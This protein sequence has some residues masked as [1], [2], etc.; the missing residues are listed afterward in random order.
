[1]AINKT[2][3]EQRQLQ[4][5]PASSWHWQW[6]WHRQLAA[7]SLAALAAAGGWRLAATSLA[8]HP[9][10]Q[11]AAWQ[12]AAAAGSWQLANHPHLQYPA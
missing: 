9:H 6:Q 1:M 4:L 12:L 10:L 7:C 3:N 2:N 11:Y 8:N 5:Q